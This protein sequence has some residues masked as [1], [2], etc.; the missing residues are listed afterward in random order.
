MVVGKREC[1]K[2]FFVQERAPVLTNKMGKTRGSSWK[3]KWFAHHFVLETLENRGCDLRPGIFFPS[4]QSVQQIWIKFGPGRSPTK[5]N[6]SYR[7]KG[8]K[9]LSQRR[10]IILS[11]FASCVDHTARQ[12]HKLAYFCIQFLSTPA[13]EKNKQVTVLRLTSK[14]FQKHSTWDEKLKVHVTLPKSWF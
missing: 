4:F 2:L 13:R 7:S 10:F 12:K 5:S 9:S 3:V 8:L 6:I 11:N 1:Q 14:E